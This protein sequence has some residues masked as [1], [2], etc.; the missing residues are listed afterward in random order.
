MTILAG[1]AAISANATIQAEICIVGAGAAGIALARDLAAAG[2]D[3]L[4]LEGGG[5]EPSQDSQSLYQADNGGQYALRAS[6]CRQRY[7]GGSTNCWEGWCRPFD[8]QDFEAPSA[9]L[10][11][12]PIPFD[13]IVPYYCQAQ[14]T[15]GIGANEFDAGPIAARNDRVLLAL[16]PRRLRSVAY[17]FSSARFRQLYYKELQDQA[18]LR[19]FTH[20]NLVELRRAELGTRIRYGLCRTLSGRPFRVEAENFVLAL[21]GIENPRLLLASR[22]DTPGGL[23]NENELVGRYFMEHPHIYQGAVLALPQEPEPESYTRNWTAR[24]VDADNLQGVDATVRLGLA[25][26]APV[27]KRENL[28]NLIAT[29]EP[30]RPSETEPL[31]SEVSADAIGSLLPSIPVAKLFRLEIRAEQRPLYTSRVGLT[32]REDQLGMPTVEINWNVDETDLEDI[33]RSLELFA[34]EFGRSGLGRLFL[35]QRT[36]ADWGVGQ[37]CHHL[38][39]TRMAS[40]PAQGVVDANC[41]VFGTENLFIAGSSVFPTGGCANPTLTIVALAHRLGDHLLSLN[42]ASL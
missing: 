34:L 11:G 39:T 4:L 12:W 19:L 5:L 31:L 8:P 36:A 9:D 16:D 18:N 27:R 2:R 7:L 20:A 37:G 10:E 14:Q 21:G 40:S 26:P 15:L 41:R 32:P 3:V 25:L 42:E 23:G 33:G 6:S 30:Y 13:S 28:L 38:G 1:E 22:E 29:L 17:Q 24:T 35:P